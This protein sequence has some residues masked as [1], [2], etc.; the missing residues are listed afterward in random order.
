MA[1]GEKARG[2]KTGRAQVDDD[3]GPALLRELFAI[4]PMLNRLAVEGRAQHRLSEPRARVLRIL[5]DDG[6]AM[7]KD[8]S[9]A[10]AITPRAVTALVDRLEADALVRRREHPHDRRVTVVELT[11]SGNRLVTTM[12]TGYRQFARELF[13]GL[14]ERDLGTGRRV[15]DQVRERLEARQPG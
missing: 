7:M 4:A 3:P 11:P 6:P 15:L 8:L 5:R 9:R 12:R 2:T 13:D 14:S 1:T 10:L